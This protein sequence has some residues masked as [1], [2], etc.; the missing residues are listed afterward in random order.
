[1][2]MR[3]DL[4]MHYIE[5]PPKLIQNLVNNKTV[6]KNQKVDLWN[7]FVES[8]LIGITEDDCCIYPR[9]LPLSYLKSI[10]KSAY[11]ISLFVFRLL[12]LPVKEIKAIIP[13]GPIRDFLINELEVLKHRPDRLVGSF[14]F[15]MAIVGKPEV[16]NPPKLL[17]INE[18]GFGGLSRSTYIQNALIHLV[19]QLGKMVAIDS[20]RSEAFNMKRLGAKVARFQYEA[21]DW[22]EEVL[23]NESKKYGVDIHLISPKPLRFGIAKKEYPL[24]QKE[25]VKKHQ[26]HILIGKNFRPDLIQMGYSFELDDYLRAPAMYHKI[27]SS[28]TPQYSPFITGLVASKSILVLLNDKQLRS[29]LLGK[30]QTLEQSILPAFFLDG[31]KE[32][33]QNSSENYVIKHVD[34]LGGEMVFFGSELLKKIK[35]IKKHKEKHWVAQ[36]KIFLNTLLVDGIISESRKVLSDL[37]VFIQYDWSKDRFNHFKVG[38]FISR[39][40]HKSYKVNVSGGGIQ[41]PVLFAP[42]K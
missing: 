12:S 16:N 32:K 38:G 36:N 6:R 35:Q 33:V 42:N 40:T 13:Q 7:H 14:R 1:M 8:D 22:E 10:E 25:D 30:S 31:H 39:A 17:E 19:P 18:I 34:G 37:G 26:N 21:Y 20:A 4:D 27:V 29:K 3:P 28:K 15:D 5:I 2:A 24:L 41:V 9:V 11:E 23:V